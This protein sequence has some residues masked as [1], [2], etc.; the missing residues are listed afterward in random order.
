M[1]ALE[2]QQAVPGWPVLLAS[3]KKAWD[4]W[5]SIEYNF[6]EETAMFLHS[7]KS[8]AMLFGQSLARWG[9]HLPWVFWGIGGWV[10]YMATSLCQWI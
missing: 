8:A 9:T 1:Y 10:G 7:K 3:S 4:I 6:D 2:Q 5:G